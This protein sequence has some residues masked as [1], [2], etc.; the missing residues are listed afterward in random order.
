MH[1]LELMWTVIFVAFILFWTGYGLH[2]AFGLA[3]ENRRQP[4]CI[5]RFLRDKD[6]R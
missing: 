4:K 2:Y 6:W 3:K 1:G 5:K